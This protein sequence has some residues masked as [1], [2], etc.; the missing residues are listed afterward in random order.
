MIPSES[1]LLLKTSLIKEF[2]ILLEFILSVTNRLNTVFVWIAVEGI[3]FPFSSLDLSEAPYKK[4]SA[5]LR[6][7]RDENSE[8]STAITW[9]DFYGYFCRTPLAGVTTVKTIEFAGKCSIRASVDARKFI[10]FTSTE[11]ELIPRLRIQ[12]A[13]FEFLSPNGKLVSD[14]NGMT[15]YNLLKLIINVKMLQCLSKNILTFK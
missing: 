3:V 6:P 12:F 7:M 1:F 2:L 4:R 13:E 15:I 9:S 11:D 5:R 14:K 8:D 10:T